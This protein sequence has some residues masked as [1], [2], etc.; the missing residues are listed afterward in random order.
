MTAFQTQLEKAVAS[1]HRRQRSEPGPHHGG[2]G[3]TLEG[4]GPASIVN[5]A[6]AVSV[7]ALAGVGLDDPTVALGLQFLRKKVS[8]HSK[9]LASHPEA[10]GP[11]ARY[12]AY[13]LLGLTAY[14]EAIDE[15]GHAEAIDD[16][17]SWLINN[18]LQE[19]GEPDEIGIGWSDHPD[20]GYVSMLSTCT[21]AYALARVPASIPAGPRAAELG[22]YARRRI[23]ESARGTAIR[24]RWWPTRTDADFSADD[25]A[26]PALTALAVLAL[27]EGGTRSQS[28]ARA[29][30]SWLLKRHERWQQHRDQEVNIIDTNWVHVTCALGVRA[31]LVPPAG[32]DPQDPRLAIAI[33]FL[34]QLWSPRAGEWLH[35]HPDAKPSTSADYH[36][37]AAIHAMRRSWRGFDPVQHVLGGRPVRRRTPGPGAAQPAQIE[38]SH[39]IITVYGADG[40]VLATR[41][42]ASHATSM[43]KLITALVEPLADGR[44]N[45]S[46]AERSF[47]AE[48]LKELTGIDK[49]PEYIRRLN[50]HILDAAIESS[51]RPCLL[52][53]RIASG[54]GAMQ[55]RYVLLGEQ[56]IIG[57]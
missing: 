49:V 34:D 54:Q 18:A 56:A 33:S 7:L 5:T 28:Y 36:V 52:V 57:D 47:T 37:S 16:C 43:R 51:G 26:S 32:T 22:V 14:P 4:P 6:E 55:D 21:A 19:R 48:E 9:G 35:G 41:R 40:T 42:F 45:Q 3:V 11:M 1:L 17:V 2:W 25:A 20:V 8:L 39:N 29:G 27:A 10:R 44:T 23:R 13:G 24:T 46:Q 53:N 31:A 50:Q 15:P 12:A 30:A 38:W